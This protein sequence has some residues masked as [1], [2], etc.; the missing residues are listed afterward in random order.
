[1]PFRTFQDGTVT[2]KNQTRPPFCHSD[3]SVSGAEESTTLEK[4]PSQGKICNL[5]RSLRSFH[6]VGITCRG[7]RSTSQVV[8]GTLL[9]DES[10]P[11]HCTV[12]WVVAFIHTGYIRNIASPSPGLGGDRLPPLHRIRPL[13]YRL[14][15]THVITC[16][17]LA[18]YPILCYAV[19]GATSTP[20]GGPPR[21]YSGVY[22]YF[23]PVRY[24]K[25]VLLLVT[26]P[27]LIEF[28]SFLVALITLIIGIIDHKNKK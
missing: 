22:F 24:R 5:S 23:A 10:S 20:A 27:N 4:E 12:Y 28:C 11:L 15:E 9:G 21:C 6:S 13:W 25:G 14:V 17:P 1:M 26:W 16:I 18:F 8:F 2:D 7:V 19:T 3:R